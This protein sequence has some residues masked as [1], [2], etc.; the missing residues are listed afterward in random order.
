MS[1]ATGRQVALAQLP[2]LRSRLRAAGG[3]GGAQLEALRER[4]RRLRAALQQVRQ[5]RQLQRD[6]S[7]A[8]RPPVVG[9][10]GYTNAGEAVTSTF[11]LCLSFSKI[12]YQFARSTGALDAAVG[13]DVGLR[14]LWACPQ[15]RPR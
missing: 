3:G 9:V 7:A 2:Y 15:G 1:C 12:W 11:R 4:E 5:R 14:L 10:V 6:A 8:L 13:C